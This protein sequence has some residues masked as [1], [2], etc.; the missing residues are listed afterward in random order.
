MLRNLLRLKAALLRAIPPKYWPMAT[1]LKNQIFGYGQRSYAQHGEDLILRCIFGPKTSGFY[2]DVGAHHPKFLSNSYFFYRRGWKGINIDPMPQ[3][4]KKFRKVRGRDTNLEYALSDKKESQT[5]YL[6]NNSC[7]N[8]LSVEYA[9]ELK[10]D[11]G[12]VL[13]DQ[14]QIT[15]ATLKEV[16]DEHLPP[17]MK[18]DF[19][20]VDAEMWD[21]PILRGNDWSKYRPSVVLVEVQG[22]SLQRA[23]ESDIYRFL[24]AQGYTLGYIAMSNLF[25]IENSR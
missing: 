22:F 11:P 16:L 24:T 20:S 12:I 14:K 18:I 6:F 21:L 4:M 9:E 19:L 5:L 13:L 8:T 7:A 17:Q 1:R 25:F 15:T 3:I 23:E 2:V 10:K